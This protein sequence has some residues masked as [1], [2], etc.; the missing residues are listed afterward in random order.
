MSY[1]IYKN[2]YSPYVKKLC[3]LCTFLHTKNIPLY[4]FHYIKELKKSGYE[5]MVISHSP[6]E[7]KDIEKLTGIC[8]SIVIKDNFG[9]DFFAWK[10]GLE[11]CDNGIHL[12]NLL[13]TN[14][15]IIGPFYE[16]TPIFINMNQKFDFWGMTENFEYNYHIQ[17]YFL[18]A[19]RKVIQGEAWVN[20]WN[21]LK[22][23]ENKLDIVRNY[24]VELTQV[25]LKDKTISIGA[26][27][28]IQAVQEKF[29]LPAAI[30]YPKAPFWYGVSN[31]TIRYWKE[32]IVEFNFPFIKKNLFFGKEHYHVIHKNKVFVYNVFPINWKN[33]IKNKYGSYSVSLIENYLSKFFSETVSYKYSQ[34]EQYKSLI[35]VKK[36]TSTEQFDYVI[37]IMRFYSDQR[38]A[39]ELIIDCAQ[40]DL[41]EFESSKLMEATKV[42]F[43]RNLT[44]SEKEQHKF[45]LSIEKIG[46]II[47]ADNESTELAGSYLYTGASVVFIVDKL[48]DDHSV[49]S[50]VEAATLISAKLATPSPTVQQI[51]KEKGIAVRLFENIPSVQAEVILSL[52]SPPRL[53]VG[54]IGISEKTLQEEHLDYSIDIITKSSN[55]VCVVFISEREKQLILQKRNNGSSY[56]E[57]LKNNKQVRVIEYKNNL[58][59]LLNEHSINLALSYFNGY[60]FPDEYLGIYQ[61][62]IPLLNFFSKSLQADIFRQYKFSKLDYFNLG[63]LSDKLSKLATD[64]EYY[65]QHKADTLRSF[66]IFFEKFKYDNLSNFLLTEVIDFS[67][68]KQPLPKIT[69]VFHFHF[70]S[71]DKAT[72]EYY[73][74]RLRDFYG[75]NIDYLFSITEDSY[76]IQEH[77]ESL[78]RSFP[79]C[80]IK[81]VPN[82]GR[83]IGA[84]FLL[85]DQYFKSKSYSEYLIV[86]H[87]KKSLH[88]PYW[89][90]K[91]WIESLLKIIDP[92]VFPDILKKISEHT[93]IGII[94]TAERIVD[95][96]IKWSDQGVMR[97]PVFE[98][99]NDLLHEMIKKYNIQ[100]TDYS[101]VGGTMFWIRHDVLK[102]MHEKYDFLAKFQELEEGNVM[103]NNGSTITHCWERLLCWIST[104]L[105]YKVSGI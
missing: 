59:T 102:L 82:K 34:I 99:N 79:G 87:D 68:L 20:Y 26:W 105:G 9:Y 74:K 49:D 72:F 64:H 88:L 16:L 6:L 57:S 46:T 60:H 17:S 78:R 42:T 90:A 85:F 84:K 2:D 10:K 96:I 83:D 104:N 101:F 30:N 94:G 95:C 91:A 22:L 14:D 93:D 61:S 19:N 43:L 28:S 25:L 98:W 24:E 54:I 55:H 8:C 21:N 48:D 37:R 75:G 58:L 50:Y 71:F 13:L 23:Y 52:V 80:V 69:V 45:Q 36:I 67:E 4:T 5:T 15:S 44:E 66:E 81:V 76:Q 27:A 97:K 11:L 53:H 33:T 31:P 38:L 18:H 39:T 56:L 29:S 32:L 65:N 100:I 41:I 86:M 77:A 47:I 7:E 51:F 40:Q 103:D 70:Y 89:E 35:V 63:E 73:K 92:V 3:I 62:K 1:Q 12:D